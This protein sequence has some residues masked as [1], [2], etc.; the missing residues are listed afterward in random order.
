M[1]NNIIVETAVIP[2]KRGRKPK[3]D[4][5]IELKEELTNSITSLNT[6]ISINSLDNKSNSINNETQSIETKLIETPPIETPPIET[7]PIKK[8]GR[9][10][11]GGKIIQQINSNDNNTSYKQNI[12]LH[13]NFSLKDLV[14]ENTCH[15]DIEYYNINSQKNETYQQI[16]CNNLLS[17]KYYINVTD[18]L[19]KDNIE[20]EEKSTDIQW[21][22]LTLVNTEWKLAQDTA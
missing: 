17:K 14:N 4:K 3:Q 18:N 20:E 19:L 22:Q 8:R 12:I 16:E 5:I 2:K 13:L 7:P 21:H 1:V 11:K 15:S 10:P 9:K 6:N